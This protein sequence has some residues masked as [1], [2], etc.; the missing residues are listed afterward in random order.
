MREASFRTQQQQG[1]YGTTGAEPFYYS[2]GYSNAP[3]AQEN[4]LKTNFMKMVRAL[5]EEMNKFLKEIPENI[6]K[7]WEGNE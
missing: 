4:D 5:K 2:S 1:Q 7:K 3:E 6:G